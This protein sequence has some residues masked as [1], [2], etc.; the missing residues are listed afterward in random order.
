MLNSMFPESGY[1]LVDQA[2]VAKRE[3]CLG[4]PNLTQQPLSKSALEIGETLFLNCV[5]NTV[6]TY[7]SSQTRLLS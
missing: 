2:V 3:P 1:A 7:R 5:P 4:E 6:G